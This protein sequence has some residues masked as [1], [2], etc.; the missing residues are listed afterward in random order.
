MRTADDILFAL[1]RVARRIAAALWS[2]FLSFSLIGKGFSVAVGLY[3]VAWMSGQVGLH[4]IARDLGSDAWFVLRL[5]IAAVVIR[6][7]WLRFTQRSQYP[8]W[9]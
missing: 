4:R 8:T 7:L 2:R 6:H 1:E 3:L 9:Y 5:V